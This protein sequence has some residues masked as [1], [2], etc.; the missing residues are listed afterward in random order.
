MLC[1]VVWKRST[2]A[3]D[4]NK[5]ILHLTCALITAYFR[6]KLELA[7]ACVPQQQI[8]LE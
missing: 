4:L 7:W 6:Q 2:L 5:V 3:I 1:H 8:A